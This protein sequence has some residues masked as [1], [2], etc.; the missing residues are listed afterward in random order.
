MELYHF[1]DRANMDSVL[2]NGLRASSKYDVLA[3]IRKNVVFCWLRK[4]DNK[5]LADNQICFRINVD[6]ER[7]LVADMD[8]ISM[9]M[10]Y[11]AYN[12]LRKPNKNLPKR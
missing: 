5:L 10:M 9:A 6:E 1:T 11:K 12:G 8:Y 4:E 3:S 7:C 2:K